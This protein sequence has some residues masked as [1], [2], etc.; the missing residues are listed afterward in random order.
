LPWVGTVNVD[1]TTYMFSPKVL[2]RAFTIEPQRVDLAGFGSSQLAA[3]EGLKL[4]A[5]PDSLEPVDLPSP[6]DW[7]EFAEL[8]SLCCSDRTR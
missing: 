6:A 2:D 3:D 1:E 5:V 7:K 4:T 8:L